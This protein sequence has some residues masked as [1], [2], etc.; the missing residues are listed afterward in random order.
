MEVLMDGGR[1]FQDALFC[2]DHIE[3]DAGKQQVLLGIPSGHL[4]GPSVVGLI[5]NMQN[6]QTGALVLGAAEVASELGIE[7]MIVVVH[8]VA[9]GYLYPS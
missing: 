6:Q 9:M 7:V 2:N 5:I 4:V 3:H 1:V 8:K